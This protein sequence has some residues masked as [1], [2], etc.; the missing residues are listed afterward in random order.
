M[1]LI[2]VQYKD[3]KCIT[4]ELCYCDMDDSVFDY[5]NHFALFVHSVPD[6]E[7]SVQELECF[8][9]EMCFVHAFSLCFFLE[10][11]DVV[12]KLCVL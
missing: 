12:L 10:K 11:L 3:F 6:C 8:E 4:I 9:L 2:F 1:L 5:Y 7:I